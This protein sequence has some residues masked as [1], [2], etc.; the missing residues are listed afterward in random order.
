MGSGK[1]EK[2]LEKRWLDEAYYLTIHNELL[3][4]FPKKHLLFYVFTQGKHEDFPT[5]S[6]QENVVFPEGIAEK[7]TFLAFARSDILVLSRSSFSYK[8]ALLNKGLKIC[9][10]GFWHGYPDQPDWLVADSFGKLPPGPND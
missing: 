6:K 4:M 2:S 7:E 10:P 3:E 1:P 8:A 5:L 9:P